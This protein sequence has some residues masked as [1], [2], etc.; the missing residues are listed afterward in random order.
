MSLKSDS[1]TRTNF[2]YLVAATVSDRPRRACRSPIARATRAFLDI[3]A[4]SN[5][6]DSR[7]SPAVLE[8]ALNRKTAGQHWDR[9]NNQRL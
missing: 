3:L 8:S 9:T 4:V 7:L 1:Y 2:G 6:L 5:C